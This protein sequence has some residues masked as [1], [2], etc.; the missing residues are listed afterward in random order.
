[1]IGGA[2]EHGSVDM[3]E[4][5]PRLLERLDAA[6]D[7]DEPP[8]H[9]GLQPIDAAVIERRDIA[10][11]LRAQP[12]QPRL[13][14]MHPQCVGARV[15]NPVR[16]RIECRLGILF[17]DADAALDRDRDRHRLFHRR[18]AGGDQVWHLHQAGA[19]SARLDAVRRTADV[20]V[21]LVIA[22]RL[23]DARRLGKLAGSEPPSCS[24][25]GCS[26]GSNPSNRSRAPWMTASA[27][28]ISV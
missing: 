22:E 2:A 28:T 23:A 6:V 9:A 25:T 14:R 26:T 3:V 16:K 7:A 8:G 5:S 10:V 24:A 12:F 4:M 17:V 19:E 18:D 20:E 15:E 13:A 1:V 27:T 11:F 21:D